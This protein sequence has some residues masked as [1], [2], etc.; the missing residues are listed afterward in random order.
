M[1]KIIVFDLD[2]TLSESK[3]KIDEEMSLLLSELT[4][5]YKVAI[6]T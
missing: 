2:D 5:K 1:Y 6:I 3:Q 4:K